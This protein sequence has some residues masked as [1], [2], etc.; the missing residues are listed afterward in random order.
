[1]LSYW[2][3]VATVGNFLCYVPVRTF[4]F[5]EDM[6]T[7]AIGFACSP[8]WIL[9]VLGLPFGL[10]LVHFFTQTEPREIAV[11]ATELPS[12]SKHTRLPYSIRNL[13]LL[14]C[15]R[16]GQQRRCLAPSLSSFCLSL[17][18]FDDARRMAAD[19]PNE[20]HREL[21]AIALAL[22]FRLRQPSYRPVQK[23]GRS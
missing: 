7:T 17:R 15:S 3:L 23:H 1:M 5:R 12:A 6:H 20:D 22:W 8:W 21:T 10:A 11:A 16:M 9:L 14:R 4:S 2:L 19:K 18:P 13:R